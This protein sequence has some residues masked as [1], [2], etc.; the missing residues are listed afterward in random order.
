MLRRWVG[1]SGISSPLT[2]QLCTG[3][4]HTTDRQARCRQYGGDLERRRRVSVVHGGIQEEPVRSTQAE[5]QTL[6]LDVADVLEEETH[7]PSRRDRK[8]VVMHV[9]PKQSEAR[10]ELWYRACLEADLVLYGLDYL[11]RRSWGHT[12]LQPGAD[13]SGTGTCQREEGRS[14]EAL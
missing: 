14:P 2:H 5:F 8:D 7:C 13:G 1:I 3:C 12:S 4:R 6:P 9:C 10:L 11:Q